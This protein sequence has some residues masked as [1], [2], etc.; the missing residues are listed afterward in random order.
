MPVQADP[1]LTEQHAPGLPEARHRTD[2]QDGD[3]RKEQQT[4]AAVQVTIR[5]ILDDL[6]EEFDADLYRQKCEAVY[7]HVYDSYWDDGHSVYTRN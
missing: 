7:V 4:R 6:P 3:E 5:E 2:G 1:R